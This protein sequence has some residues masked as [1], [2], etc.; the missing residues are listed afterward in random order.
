MNETRRMQGKRALVTGSGTGIG[1]G[2]ALEF[3]HEG[4]DVAFHYAHS[5]QG[6]LEGVEEARRMGVRAEAFQ[7]DFTKV[8]EARQLA[9]RAIEF[10]G[11]LDILVNNAGVTLNMPFERVTVEQFDTLYAVNIRAMFFVIQ[12]SL[13]ALLESGHGAVINLSSVHAYESMQDYSVYAG[14]K[15]A[16]VSFTRQLAIELAPRG[17]RVNCIAPG[18][19]TVESYYQV[20][21]G[22][23][24]EAMG[25]C[26]PAGFAGQPRDIARA[27]IFLASDDARYIIGQTLVVDGGTTSWLPFSEDFKKPPDACFGLGYVP[28]V[29]G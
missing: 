9:H 28:G 16:I 20:V 19:T 12:A 24:P 23:D 4:A 25:K 5:S 3:A 18:A 1:K 14:T 13:P 11:G 29:T 7:A 26:I 22:Y 2:V 10:L 17:I 6:A 21:R 27:A 8:E 15:G